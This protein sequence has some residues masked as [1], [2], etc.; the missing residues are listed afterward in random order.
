MLPEV[1]WPEVT[2]VT[3]P[4]VT[5]FSPRFFLTIVVVQN[6]PLHEKLE[7]TKRIIRS[8]K[9]NDKQQWD[10]FT[11]TIEGKKRGENDVTSGHVT[12]G[13]FIFSVTSPTVAHLSQIIMAYRSSKKSTNDQTP[14][15]PPPPPPPPPLP[16][17]L[18]SQSNDEEHYYILKTKNSF[19]A[20]GTSIL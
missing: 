9:W 20:L 7:D 1:T 12:S 15:I 6:V 2:S 19:F 8:R 11:T 13:H 16:P 5:S 14:S 18:Y 10:I 3:W 17:P 4:E